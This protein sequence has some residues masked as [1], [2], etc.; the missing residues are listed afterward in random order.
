MCIKSAAQ[1]SLPTRH[2]CSRSGNCDPT[3]TQAYGLDSDPGESAAINEE[4]LEWNAD[5][6][7]HREGLFSLVT[8]SAAP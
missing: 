8:V 6:Q 1:A 3:A 4:V 2:P 5:F 7:V